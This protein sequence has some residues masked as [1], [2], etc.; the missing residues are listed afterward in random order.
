VF[1]LAAILER[2]VRWPV[3]VVWV[4]AGVVQITD[5][6]WLHETTNLRAFRKGH[7]GAGVGLQNALSRVLD[8]GAQLFHRVFVVRDIALPIVTTAG[9]ASLVL[10]REH[11]AFLTAAWLLQLGLVVMLSASGA[12][13][14]G[15]R[16]DLLRSRRYLLVETVSILA[17]LVAARTMRASW[18]YH[19][20][21][22][23]LCLGNIW[24]LEHMRRFMRDERPARFSLPAVESIE[25][26]GMVDI[27][28]AAWVDELATRV[29][30]GERVILLHSQACRS[31]NVTNPEGTLERLYLSV[32]HRRFT[33]QVVA[34]PKAVCRYVC[35]PL[36]S[37]EAVRSELAAL[38]TGTIVELDMR[39]HDTMRP[40]L[41]ALR[42]H[43][44]VVTLNPGHRYARLALEPKGAPPPAN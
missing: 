41:D 21:L 1:L 36:P 42:S 26:V 38:P 16:L 29:K 40:E 24:S 6:Y 17:I 22:P 33:Q 31:E 13:D 4:L 10:L 12:D 37:V 39:C 7:V 3:R 18:G 23:F 9:L 8:G 34:F 27:A 15:T 44:N 43:F 30:A 28:N 25:S 19:L 20:L 5:A 35:L 14:A 2:N 11:R 32:G